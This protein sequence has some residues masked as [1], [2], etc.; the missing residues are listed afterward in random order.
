MILI[1]LGPPGAGKGTQAKMLAD[2]LHLPHIS[3]GDLFRE[4]IR[5]GTALG[6][7]AKQ[8]MEKGNLVPD[9]L[10]LDMLFD[11]VAQKDCAN[12][13]ILDGVPRTLGQAESFSAHLSSNAPL[14]ALNLE[15]PDE[16]IVE[17]ITK[18]V[19]CEQ[20]GTPY[21]LTYSPPK[22]EGVCDKCGGALYQRTDD[23]KEVVLKRLKVYHDQTAPLIDYYSKKKLLHTIDARKSKEEILTQILTV[24]GKHP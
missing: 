3:T 18:R 2:H 19:M 16:D 6:E 17:R 1:M 24:L 14:L 4:N 11:R 7:K 20:C 22:K 12:G 5:Q 23:T 8:F 9:Q 10:V 21:H 13:Y 15:L